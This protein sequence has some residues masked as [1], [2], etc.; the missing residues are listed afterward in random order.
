MSADPCLCCSNAFV[1]SPSPVA[2]GAQVFGYNRHGGLENLSS[3][4]HPIV[5]TLISCSA[6]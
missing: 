6:N 2:S 4:D 1:L 5:L 3:V